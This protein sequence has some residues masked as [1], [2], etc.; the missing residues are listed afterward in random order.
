MTARERLRAK[1]GEEGTASGMHDRC[2]EETGAGGCVSNSNS[3]L[4]HLLQWLFLLHR[5]ITVHITIR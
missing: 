4:F 5:D 2:A 3:K 1:E